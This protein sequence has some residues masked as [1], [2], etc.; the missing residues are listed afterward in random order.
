[1]TALVEAG[2]KFGS[3]EVIGLVSASDEEE[4][5]RLRCHRCKFD[6]VLCNVSALLTGRARL[7]YDCAEQSRLT[8]QQRTTI[9]FRRSLQMSRE[10]L[11]LGWVA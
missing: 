6:G 8:P 4:R 1:M 3:L 9:A 5:Y 11:P 2:E 7:C 10:P